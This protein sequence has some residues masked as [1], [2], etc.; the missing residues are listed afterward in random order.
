MGVDNN[1]NVGITSKKFSDTLG[2]HATDIRNIKG[3][4]LLC[5]NKTNNLKHLLSY[6]KHNNYMTYR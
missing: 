4:E 3:R 1:F 6:I 2:L 5:L